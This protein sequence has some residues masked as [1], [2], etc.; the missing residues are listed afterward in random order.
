MTT[1][2]IRYCAVVS[3]AIGLATAQQPARTNLVGA[4]E[5][6]D[7]GS[8]Q[9]SLH[10][11]DGKTVKV[12]PHAGARWLRLPPGEK[13]LTSATPITS[14]DVAAGD[15]LLARGELSEDKA[16]LAATTLVVM[17]KGDI[18]KKQQ[19][20]R[21]EWAKRGVGGIV[22]AVD[23]G[24]GTV[25]ITMRTAEGKKPLVIETSAQTS[26]RRYAP[27]SVKFADAKP[28]TMAEVKPGDQA[29]ALGTKSEDGGKYAADELVSGT[30]RN[31]A[32]TILAIDPAAQT[33]KVTDLATK[34]PLVVR[35]N[36]DSTMRKLPEMVARMIAARAS[37]ATPGA[38]GSGGAGGPG[39]QGAGAQRPQAGQP[40]PGGLA[41]PG[42]SGGPGGPGGSGG[43]PRGGDIQQMI[44]RMPALKLEDLKPGDAVIVSS[45]EGADPNQVTA[46]TLVA[47]VEPIL[48]A[49]PGGSQRAA[50]LGSWNLD[51]GGGG[52]V[53]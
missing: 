11:D 29:R 30:F 39:G 7:P 3:L 48:T 2:C 12:T 18:A 36:A 23:A 6:I 50:M 13:S 42:G 46:I 15:R 17:S 28:A 24:A 44:E 22:T 33:I 53:E 41:G 16:A 9:I 52:G 31:V 34:K 5:S 25:T 32:A 37:G 4:V 27:G 1:N 20:D 49:A 35:V 19:A 21:A 38:G 26:V 45:T 43:P 10:T 14:K 51:M 47:G 8:G 40:G